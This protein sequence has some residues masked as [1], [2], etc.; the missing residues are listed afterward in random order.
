MQS[1]S[2]LYKSILAVPHE[3]EWRVT[4]AGMV[5]GQDKIVY[6]IGGNEVS[7]YV[8]RRIFSGDG[9]DVG[10]CCSATFTCTMLLAS[11]AI[12]RMASVLAEYRIKDSSG[13]I[14]EWIKAGT[15]YIDTRYSDDETGT[16]ALTCYDSMLKADGVGGKTYIELTSFTSWP[17]S[18]SAVVNEIAS[19]MGVSVDS[20]TVLNSGSGYR[21]PYPNDLTMREVLGQI[22]AAHGGNFIITEQNELRLIPIIGD[23]TDTIDL[24][25]NFASLTLSHVFQPWSKVTVYWSDENAFQAG[26]DTGRELVIDCTF[27]EQD[28]ANGVLT[29]IDGEQ[30]QPFSTGSTI[31][32]LAAE[33]GDKI[34]FV[35]NN[36][37]TISAYIWS[38]GYNC[39]EYPLPDISAP[40]ED[41]VDHEYPYVTQTQRQMRRMVKLGT[42]YYGVS[43]TKTSGI[44]IERSDGTSKAIFNS[45]TFEMDALVDGVMT[46]KIYFDPA[47]GNYVFDG[48]LGADAI[49]T[50]SLYAETGDISE[51]T[52][53]RLS[54]SRRIRKYIL[55]DTSDDNY[56]KIQDQYIQLI[57]GTL[58]RN[59]E[60]LTEGSLPILTETDIILLTEAEGSGGELAPPVQATNRYGQ[61]LYWQDEPVG[62]TADGYPTDA[63]GNQIYATT[64]V[65][66]WA[67]YTYAYDELVKAQLAFDQIGSGDNYIPTL[68]LGA[69]NGAGLLQ[70]FIRKSETELQMWY[71]NSQNQSRGI[72]MGE[73]TDIVGLRKT[74]QMDFS[75]WDSGQFF[76]TIDGG[77]INSYMV[78]FDSQDRPVKI[79]DAQGHE[80]EVVW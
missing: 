39:N 18:P 72:Y 78:Q 58:K 28:T 6:K 42:P 32:D 16:I 80:T 43:I 41:A 74:T 37:N 3:T 24:Y 50:D 51:L 23:D 62:H 13:N 30:Y 55:G 34:T 35:D 15:F 14:S 2:T 63:D 54:T 71:V 22:A 49:F 75:R 66:D 73:Y 65:T 47:K 67:V 27:A 25:R 68:I 7:P 57:T 56:I 60:L 70:G 29:L 11:S 77:N 1:T 44:T 61:P 53:D 59:V 36:N 33:L 19:I 48:A 31:L 69:G 8:E 45:D 52:V 21:V 4:I 9:P 38:I 79:R 40:G 12:P 5:Y 20:R 64:D 10:G 46:P 76:E 26:D 17:Q